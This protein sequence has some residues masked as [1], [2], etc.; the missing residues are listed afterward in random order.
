MSRRDEDLVHPLD[1]V[2]TYWDYYSR[3]KDDITDATTAQI[4]NALKRIRA[5][6]EHYPKGIL[7]RNKV[8]ERSRQSIDALLHVAKSYC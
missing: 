2:V 4:V 6:L 7:E 3:F 1:V 5:R 8:G